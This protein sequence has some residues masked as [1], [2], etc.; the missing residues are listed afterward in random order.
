MQDSSGYDSWH[1]SRETRVCSLKIRQFVLTLKRRRWRL[2]FECRI[3][4]PVDCLLLFYSLAPNRLGLYG[5]VNKRT[6]WMPWRQ[7]AMKDVVACDKLRGA[8]KYALIR[9]FPNGET[10]RFGG[11]FN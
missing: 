8:G 11:T 6:W 9:R 2:W 4:E 3:R 7:K 5:Q 10:H 1:A